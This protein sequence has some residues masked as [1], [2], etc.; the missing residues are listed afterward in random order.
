MKCTEKGCNGEIDKEKSV[1][2]HYGCSDVKKNFFPCDSCGKLYRGN[3]SPAF[4]G[5]RKAFLRYG[6]IVYQD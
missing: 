4:G 1:P 3:G 5:N 2:L 6:K